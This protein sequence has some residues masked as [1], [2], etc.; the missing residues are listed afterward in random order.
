[1]FAKS[2]IWVK[3]HLC[4]P[5]APSHQMAPLTF[6]GCHA[7][8][9]GWPTSTAPGCSG[10]FVLRSLNKDSS[11]FLALGGS[12]KCKQEEKPNY[13]AC[14]FGGYFKTLS[15]LYEKNLSQECEYCSAL[16]AVRIV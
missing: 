4:Y 5:L 2:G 7:A 1:M 13:S 9:N 10:S 16:F 3:G 12:T 11:P 6:P 15:G 8:A 14:R